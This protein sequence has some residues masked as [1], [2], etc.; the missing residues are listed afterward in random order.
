MTTHRTDPL[1]GFEV[2]VVGPR[3]GRPNQPSDGCPFCVGGIESP[4]PYTTRAFTNRWPSFPDDRCEVVLYSPDHEASLATMSEAEVRA[5]VDLWAERTTELGARPDVAYVLAFENH[6]A[7]VGATIAHP[8][9]QVFAYDRVPELPARELARLAEGHPL[10]DVDP[11][12]ERLVVARDG[13]QAWVPFA[14]VHPYT[15]RVAPIVARPD[16]PSLDDAERT[17][18]ARILRD[19]LGRFDRRFATPM[20]YMFWWHQRPTDGGDWPGATL[21]LEIVSPWR[22][23]GVARYVAGAELGSGTFVNPVV[24]EEAAAALREAGRA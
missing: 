23:E 11:D 10:R 7:E 1:T 13:W 6:G 21:H 4:E 19:V 24:P 16:L 2:E 12:D 20:P 8:H 17:G 9:G 5:V 22:A 3:Q 18:L 14:P 15:V